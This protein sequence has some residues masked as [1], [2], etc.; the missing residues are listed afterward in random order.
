MPAEK[1]QIRLMTASPITLRACIPAPDQV[2][3]EQAYFKYLDFYKKTLFHTPFLSRGR[4]VTLLEYRDAKVVF[5]VDVWFSQLP[6]AVQ[7]YLL[8]LQSKYA[9]WYEENVRH[10]TQNYFFCTLCKS[11]QSNLQRHYMREHARWR[12]IWF[13]PIPGCPSSLSTKEGLV[14]HL[15]SRP[16]RRGIRTVT[17][18]SPR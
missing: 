14:K 16:H 10:L 11:K 17:G 7:R 1:A 8:P 13:C 4:A 12:S 3:P 15:Q 9:K 18:Q 6:Q 5:E 2:T